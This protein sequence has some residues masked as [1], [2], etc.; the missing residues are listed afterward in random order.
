MLNNTHVPILI[1]WDVDPDRWATPEDRRLA[2]KMAMDLC[3]E[4][5]VRSTFFFTADFAHEYPSEIERMRTTG[6]EIGCH[7]LNHA[8]DEEYDRMPEAIQRAYIKQATAKLEALTDSPIRA[9]RSPRV[10]ISAVT[11][12]LLAENGY[13]ADSSICSQRLDLVS[14]NLI[15]K[16]W[17]VAPRRPYRPHRANPFKR[18]DL[19]IWEVPLS[20]LGLPFLS[21]TLNV[22]RVPVTKLFF[23]LLYEESK[24]TGKPIVYLS[25]PTEFIVP[26]E[27]CQPTLRYFSPKLLSPSYV[28]THGFLLRNL[29]LRMDGETL[30]KSS[31]ELFA[32][33]AACPDTAF[34]T[35][36]EYA[37]Q[38][39]QGVS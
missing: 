5:D 39:L 21:K 23:R 22:L 14:S 25:H 34:M 20:A 9:F 13:L 11:L 28:R 10:K 36:S 6:H 27:D 2:L 12:Q 1:T 35:V 26:E 24:R 38:N 31:R 4:L 32:Y 8:G 7:G 3:Q 33:M 16:G 19:P 18:G 17:L 29:L 15:N 37:S 30:F